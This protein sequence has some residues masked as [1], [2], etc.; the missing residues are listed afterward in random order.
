M[1]ISFPITLPTAQG[2]TRVTIAP[3]SA[4]AIN[5]SPFTGQQQVYQHPLQMLTASIELPPMGRADAATFIA[6]LISLQGAAGTFIF[7]DPAWTSPRGIGTGTPLI[8]GAG[9]TGT[10]LNTDGWT[11]SQT[12]IL[13]AGDWIQVG[14]GS[15]RQLCMVL[16]D[17]NS[18][19][20]GEA[21][22]ELFPRIRTAYADNVAITTTNPKGVWRLA[23]ETSFV[24]DVGAITRGI[25]VNAMEA[26]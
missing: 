14:T 13:R 23:G 2:F 12:N 9:Q 24:Q 18:N 22:L 5:T 19:G 25:V 11:N 16:V 15:T 6:A 26:F 4:V 3:R 21:V 8:N 17:A 1:A 10:T 20:A 7:G